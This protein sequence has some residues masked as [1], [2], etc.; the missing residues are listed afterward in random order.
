MKRKD[1]FEKIK[2]YYANIAIILLSVFCFAFLLE[3]TSE[4]L[5]QKVIPPKYRRTGLGAGSVAGTNSRLWESDDPYYAKQPWA[6]QQQID[7]EASR[8]KNYHPFVLWRSAPLQSPTINIDQ[9]GFRV[10]PGAQC[11]EGAYKVFVFGGS[12]TWGW[13]VPDYATVPA[14]IQQELQKKTRKNICVVN[15]GEEGYYSTHEVLA[16]FLQ[17]KNGRIPNHVIFLD[18]DNEIMST[19]V[20][21][22]NP[23][24][25]PNE[26]LHFRFLEMSATLLNKSTPLR[27]RNLFFP[28]TLQILSMLYI[29]NETRDRQAEKLNPSHV[30]GLTARAVRE[31]YTSYNTISQLAK[32]YGFTYDVYL[33]PIP[34]TT[35]KELDPIELRNL[36]RNRPVEMTLSK[37]IYAE[38]RKRKESQSYPHLHI[39]EDAF[40]KVKEHRFFDR[41]HVVPEG[42]YEV[43]KAILSHFSG[44]L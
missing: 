22:V 43:A 26:N 28:Y 5:Y 2:C 4:V 12:T 29:N 1:L 15:M 8:A 30:V 36:H 31:F 21:A 32:N 42:N 35:K 16:L 18:G 9:S 44:K 40:D 24:N 38:I 19:Y 13:G 33:Q 27:M 10:T 3:K 39:I 34:Q 14:Y 20:N 17:L 11:V 7:Y 37:D 23:Y 41:Y 6:S 25:V